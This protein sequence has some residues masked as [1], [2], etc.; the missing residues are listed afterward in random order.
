MVT[1]Q[2]T[3]TFIDME[4]TSQLSGFYSWANLKHS[5]GRTTHDSSSITKC[6]HIN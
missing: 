1:N 5:R 6:K 3:Y 2:K 4:P